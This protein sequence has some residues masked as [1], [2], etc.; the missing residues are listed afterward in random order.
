[1][2]DEFLETPV[3]RQECRRLLEAAEKTVSRSFL[4]RESVSHA[5]RTVVCFA[6]QNALSCGEDVWLCMWL[7][8]CGFDSINMPALLALLK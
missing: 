5:S 7:Y 2:R 8:M 4:C 3:S 1:M 6:E